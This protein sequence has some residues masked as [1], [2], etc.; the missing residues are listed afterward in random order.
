MKIIKRII[1]AV[2]ILTATTS[3]TSCNYNSL[4][5]QEQQVNQAWAQVENQYQRRADLIPNLVNT[6]KGYTTHEEETLTKVVEARAKATSITLNADNLDEETLAKYQQAQGE[7]SGALKSLLAVTEAYPDLKANENFLNL[8]AQ[9]EGTENR[10]ATERKR[11]TEAVAEFNT[12]IKK[13]P[14]NIYAGWFG[15]KE[16]PQFKAEAG[17]EKAPEVKF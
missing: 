6:V 14:T 3:L 4:V 12:S 10:I 17:A 11:Y 7:L 9:L 8:Q 2:V 5:E 1:M 13:F 16:K 15:F